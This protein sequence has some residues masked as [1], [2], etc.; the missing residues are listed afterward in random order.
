MRQMMYV[1]TAIL[2]MSVAGF[3]QD[4]SQ[5]ISGSLRLATANIGAEETVSA[6]IVLTD[7]GR[8]SAARFEEARR[9]L[10]ERAIVRRQKMRPA[11]E[12]IQFKDLPLEGSYVQAIRPMVSKIRQTSRWFNAV[13]AEV[14]KSQIDA[15]TQLS[16]VAQVD[17]VVKLRK[18]D[19]SIEWMS[20]SAPGGGGKVNL[21][22]SLNYGSSYTQVS[23]I[24]VPAVH[25]S[26]IHGE[27]VIIGVF[28]AGFNNL[29]HPVFS[30]MDILA[31]HDFVNGDSSVADDGDMGSG[32][33][34]TNTLSVIGGYAS[35]QL[36]GPAFAASYVLAKTENTESETPVE[37]DNWIAAVEWADGYGIDVISCSLGYI[38]FDGQSYYTWAWMNGDSC[39]ITKAADMA[40]WEGIVVVNS[41]GNEGDN[42]QH[43]TLGA[44]ADGDT[45]IA[46]GAVGSNG[47]RVYFS[48]VGP[49]TDGRIKP[50]V[51][52]MGSGVK[53]ATGSPGATSYSSVDGTSFS[54]PLTAGVCALILSA[55]PSLTPFQVRDALRNTANNAI[56]P[57][58]Y[59]GWGIVN[60]LN[61]VDY[62]RAVITHTPLG[63]TENEAGP[64]PVTAT[65]TSQMTLVADSIQLVYGAGDALDHSIIMTPTGTPN[66]YTASIPSMGSNVTIGY[67]IQ[68]VNTQGIH[69]TAP[70]NAP[71]TFYSFHVGA[72]IVA[73]VI[74]HSPLGDQG[75]SSWPPDVTADVTDN[76]SVDSVIVEFFVNS[77]PQNSFVLVNQG[78]P[79]F[80]HS[81]PEVTVALNDTIRYRILAKD[82]ATV[83]NVVF[84]PP[85]GY[86][87]FRIGSL[88]VFSTDLNS[89][90]GGFTGTVEWEWGA[91]SGAGAPVPHSSPNVW[92][93]NLDGN[94]GDETYSQL[95]LPEMTVASDNASFSF[96][97]VYNAENTYDGGNVKISLNGGPFQIVT[98]VGGYPLA[99]L[100]DGNP[101]AGQPAF[102]GTNLTWTQKTFNLSGIALGGDDI[103]IRLDFASDISIT[104]IGWY[105]DD[106]SAVGIGTVIVD[107]ENENHGVPDRFSLWQNYPN[108]FNP[109]TTIRFQLPEASTVSLAIYNA[110]GQEVR[111]LLRETQKPAGTASVSWDGKDYAGRAVGSG[112]YLYRL[113]TNSGYSKVM[114]MMLLK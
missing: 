35:G 61:A 24:N 39:R 17:L 60:A 86:H 107:V 6:W 8:S 33:H 69:T 18:N 73:P 95:T 42:S 19:E 82:G 74:V 7:K 72:D 83:P 26:G 13:S 5:K 75:M 65:I 34:G 101:M 38:G 80:G 84:D 4:N 32:S 79:T 100:D 28:D 93:T 91:P 88:S 55:N 37:E 25:N 67:Y 106:F 96:W 108:P 22:D 15:L 113:T 97:H 31:T 10:S 114:K 110:L 2:G 112:V 99:A 21:V 78:G 40:T 76:L 27:G 66:Q 77:V 47:T 104:S 52:A 36:I 85:A 105:V 48:S 111:S 102:S 49:T 56:N 92:A 81:F 9:L 51:M 41:A 57:N 71:A 68:V 30:S 23:Q 98:P 3:G 103:V 46:A 64:Y 1:L 54:C 58:K 87:M 89:T 12:L 45:V 16:F 29:T 50:D 59:Y 43:N 20:S 94:Y 109:T 63:D 11:S 14:T 90:N 62:Y 53:A 70:S 44:P